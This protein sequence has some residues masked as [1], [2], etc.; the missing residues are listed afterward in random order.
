MNQVCF[1]NAMAI[2]L[3]LFT[4]FIK[5]IGHDRYNIMI[6][7]QLD[8]K[9]ITAMKSIDLRNLNNLGKNYGWAV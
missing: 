7:N 1:I 3:T 5:L 4:A 6:Y 9:V 2:A 8:Q